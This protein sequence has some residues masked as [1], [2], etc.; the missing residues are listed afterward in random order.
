M[1]GLH[2]SDDCPDYHVV[3]LDG[4]DQRARGRVR[5]LAEVSAEMDRAEDKH[6]DY[7]FDGRL[8]DDLQLLGG[9][10]EEYGE[11]SRALTYD[12]DHAGAL[13]KE[14]IQLAA[15]A[16]AWASTLNSLDERRVNY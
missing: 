8:I 14:L 10:G 15:S 6:G 9:L 3:V 5:V 11:V 1:H 4:R 13:R 7:A 2:M 12:K 16:T